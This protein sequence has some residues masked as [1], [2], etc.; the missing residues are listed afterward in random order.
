MNRITFLAL[1]VVVLVAGC[2]T[3]SSPPQKTSLELQAIQAR[4]F[5]TNKKTAFASVLSVFQD[6]G[7]IVNSAELETGFITAKSPKN[8]TT[9]IWTGTTMKDTSATAF[10][11]ELKPGV[12]KIRLNFVESMENSKGAGIAFSEDTPIQDHAIY[13]NIFL[14]ISEAIFIR[15]ASE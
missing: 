2:A 7:Y 1:F 8:A 10:I 15:S 13:N 3:P 4:D 12:T 9:S 6:Y 5:P 11:E 14:K